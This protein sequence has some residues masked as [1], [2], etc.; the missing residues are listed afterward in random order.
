MRLNEPVTQR[1]YAL[2]NDVTLMSTTD[3]QSHITYVNEAFVQASGFSA[4]ELLGQPHNLVRHP[5]MPKEAFADMW[6]TLKSGQSWS[7]LVKNR[8]KDGDHYWVRANATPIWRNGHLTGYMSVRT[9]PSRAEIEAADSLYRKMRNGEAGHLRFCRGIVVRTGLLACLSWPKKMPVSLRVYLPMLINIGLGWLWLATAHLEGS[10]LMGLMA[11]QMLGLLGCWLLY[12]KQIGQPLANLVAQAQRQASG[13]VNPSPAMD[14]IDEIGMLQR[15]L[16]QSGLNMKAL[17]DDVSIR[18]RQVSDASAQIATGNDDLNLRTEQTAANLQ[19]AAASMEQLS[20]SIRQNAEA[21]GRA[22]EKASL[23]R[24]AATDGGGAVR[25]VVSTMD[26]ISQSSKTMTEIINVINGIAFQTNILALNAAVEAARA[27]EQGRG[28]AVVAAEVRSLAQK[29]AAAAGEIKGLIDQALQG[30]NAGVQ[31]VTVAGQTMDSTQSQV[32]DASILVTEIGEV[33]TE[34]A[35]NVSQVSAAVSQ[36]EQ[37]TQKN[38]ALVD[39]LALASRNL[40]HETTR[41]SDAV[42]VFI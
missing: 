24:R 2:E 1:E 4:E 29:S 14:R 13:Q 9:T 39:Q 33:T 17:L 34:Q 30:V 12:K 28:F 27:G 32:A 42:T 26:D 11:V 38:A 19:E 21:V 15:A 40:R 8:R 18:V 10:A 35:T 20:G 37:I 6:M 22:V 5:D 41:L 7:G 25:Q 3:L 23:A 36:L 31:M 16:N